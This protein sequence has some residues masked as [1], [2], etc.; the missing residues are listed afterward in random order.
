MWTACLELANRLNSCFPMPDPCK[1]TA[2]P[3]VHQ[4]IRWRPLICRQVTIIAVMYDS[5]IA[6]G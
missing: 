5:N 6:E 1:E 4:S 2:S 3:H